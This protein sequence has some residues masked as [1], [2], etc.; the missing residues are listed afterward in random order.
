L[1]KGFIDKTFTYQGLIV[2]VLLSAFMN[3]VLRIT[4]TNPFTLFRLISPLLVAYLIFF[5]HKNIWPIC[6]YVLLLTYSTIANFFFGESPFFSAIYTLNYL[7][8]FL[9]LFIFEELQIFW[10]KNFA[11][12]YFTILKY[13][14]YFIYLLYSVK[15]IFNFNIFFNFDTYYYNNTM[16]VTP[17]DLALAISAI[18]IVIL[19]TNFMKTPE[20]VLNLFVIITINYQ[21]DSRS[22]FLANFI[23]L[24]TFAG[25]QLL[26]KVNPQKMKYQ[27]GALLIAMTLSAV[28]IYSLKDASIK[29]VDNDFYFDAHIFDPIRRMIFLEPFRLGGSVYDRTDTAV[30]GLTEFYKT[31]G[32]GLGAGGSITVLEMIYYTT[33]TAKSVH[34]FLLEWI[35]DFGWL[36]LTL[37]A[38]IVIIYFK[39][40]LNIS[41]LKS[42]ALIVFLPAVPLLG[43]SQ[44][45]GF[46]SNFLFWGTTFFI[47]YLGFSKEI[48]FEKSGV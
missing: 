13:T 21:N 34:N 28:G 45:S 24:I 26:K 16:F 38:A 15:K 48:V 32:I 5:R 1:I 7:Y 2:I 41:R 29:F 25:Y 3:S 23:S 8:L 4:P 35:L 20:K 47:F 6:L 37:Y 19:T 40:L 17:N 27:I 39:L 42:F 10:Q 43:A 30:F 11:F 18:F 33:S 12:F 46:V 14:L 22:A 31:Y 9:L 44:S 36:A